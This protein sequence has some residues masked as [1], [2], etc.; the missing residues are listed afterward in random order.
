MSASDIRRDVLPSGWS[1]A[2]EEPQRSP[3]PQRKHIL[4]NPTFISGGTEN[5]GWSVFHDVGRAFFALISINSASVTMSPHE[6]DVLSSWYC[7]LPATIVLIGTTMAVIEARAPS[8]QPRELSQL[9]RELSQ[10]HLVRPLSETSELILLSSLI[11]L[12]GFATI[13]TLSWLVGGFS[14]AASATGVYLL[15]G[16]VALGTMTFLVTHFF[17]RASMATV[18]SVQQAYRPISRRVSDF[19]RRHSHRWYFVLPLTITAL[20]IIVA[21]RVSDFALFFKWYYIAAAVAFFYCFVVF[22]WAR[23]LGQYADEHAGYLFGQ[24]EKLSKW[25]CSISI[26]L[27]VWM[28]SYYLMGIEGEPTWGERYASTVIYGAALWALCTTLCAWA[29]TL[30]LA[31]TYRLHWVQLRK[32]SKQLHWAQRGESAAVCHRIRKLGG[33]R[34]T[35]VL[36]KTLHDSSCHISA[37]LA[38][39]R[40]LADLNWQPDSADARVWLAI[41]EQRW[42]DVPSMTTEQLKVLLE[43]LDQTLYSPRN[44]FDGDQL[45]LVSIPAIKTLGEMADPKS[46]PSLIRAVTLRYESEFDESHV[47]SIENSKNPNYLNVVA[48]QREAANALKAMGC[49]AESAVSALNELLDENRLSP[50]VGEAVSA[51]LKHI[52]P[53][54]GA[55][56]GDNGS[57]SLLSELH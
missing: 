24:A 41:V 50:E 35:D 16:L 19:H 46:V 55:A 42:V 1:C 13:K 18:D 17:H 3:R 26:V 28:S 2:F 47:P 31:Y 7:T 8:K 48:T 21:E 30:F 57:T 6:I 20:A 38:A 37:R 4:P 51:A 33:R 40:E 23:A 44:R 9:D 14:D 27:I 5:Q 10:L 32:L 12:F 39:V 36:R 15:Y 11:W 56:D 34:A 49:T 25:L 43:V 45:S 54:S 22:T 29:A 53:N 52:Q